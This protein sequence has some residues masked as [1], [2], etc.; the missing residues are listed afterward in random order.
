MEPLIECRFSEHGK[1][2]YLGIGL[3][4]NTADLYCTRAFKPY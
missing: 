1:S 3:R 4:D 2:D